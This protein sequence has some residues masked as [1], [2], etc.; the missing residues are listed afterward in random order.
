MKIKVKVDDS[1]YQVEIENLNV[2]PI[3]AQ[4]GEQTFEIWPEIESGPVLA[5]PGPAEAASRPATGLPA[6]RPTGEREILSPLPGTVTEIMVSPGSQVQPGDPLLVIEAMK[7]KNT[8]RA[9]RAGTI[10][11]VH[12]IVGQSVQHKQPL[13]EFE[14]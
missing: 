2:R 10:A 14:A 12:V 3:L 7:M 9:G 6:D 11:E 1:V 8:I 5:R 4:I 13:L